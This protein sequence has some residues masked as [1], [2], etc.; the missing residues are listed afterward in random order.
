MANRC[1][2][3]AA[4]KALWLGILIGG[5]AWAAEP[6]QHIE[7]GGG[8]S[9]DLLLVRSGEFIQGS[10]VEEA[11]RGDDETP[12][13]VML[14]QDFHIGRTAVTRG[15]WECF[16]K[17]TGYRSEAETGTSGG[18]GWDGKALAQ[19]KEF[20][21]RNPGF[22]QTADH[23]VC[24]VT[25]PD[26]EAF[27]RWFEK[28]SHRKTTL[29]TEAQWEYACRAGTS[30]PWH[31]GG[32][33]ACDLVAWHKGNAADGTRPAGSK[34]ANPWGLIIGGN[35]GEW[36]LDWYA[37]YD[38]G[39]TV[40]PRQDNPNLSDKPRRVLRGGSWLRDPKHSRSAARYRVDPRSR[41]AD[42]GF[43]VVCLTS[44]IAPVV[45]APLETSIPS[46]QRENPPPAPPIRAAA[47]EVELHQVDHMMPGWL[48]LLIP[49]G[50]LVIVIRLIV[51]G[52]NTTAPFVSPSPPV[53]PRPNPT[54]RK[55]VDG[56]WIQSGLAVGTPVHLS[57]LVNG[58]NIEQSLIYQPG[59]EG[60]FVYTGTTPDKVTISSTGDLPPPLSHRAAPFS[61]RETDSPVRSRPT[62]FPPAY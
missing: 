21:W 24:L 34:Q 30:T 47:P 7:L 46:P 20:T 40:D 37:P 32:A 61:D 49:L 2:T 57:Y 44:V 39:A 41:N 36:C 13:P 23:P 1:H 5:G 15:Q 4:M 38:D 33:D 12:H 16:I 62:M 56:F 31:G 53:L 19:R 50:L 59:A 48:C 52:R 58:E 45:E 26:A 28:K 27:C 25:F 51:R 54:I 35:V 55:V 22:P 3:V 43:R 9:M 17:E 29:P 6:M 14:T 11:G 42:I 8:Q 10:P 18:F 60:Q